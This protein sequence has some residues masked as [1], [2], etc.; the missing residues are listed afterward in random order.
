MLLTEAAAQ[1]G[2]EAALKEYTPRLEELAR[3]DEHKLYRAIAERARGVAHRLAGEHAEAEARLE[4]A[5][6]MF[7]ELG[8]RWQIGRTLLELGEVAAARG[9]ADAR[10]RYYEEAMEAFEVLGAKPDAERAR[11]AVS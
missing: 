11:V 3:R 9:E 1:R 5:L 4:G 8:T 6:A 2:D 7:R 10:R